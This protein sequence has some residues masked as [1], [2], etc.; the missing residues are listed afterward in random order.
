MLSPTIK[1]RTSAVTPGVPLFFCCSLASVRLAC[2]AEEAVFARIDSVL[3]SMNLV[4]K[5]S[6]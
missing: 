2:S 1:Q 5:T 4:A 3:M 6:N